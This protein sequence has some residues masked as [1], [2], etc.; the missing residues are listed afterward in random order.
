MV[1]VLVISAEIVDGGF[2]G[3]L[4]SNFLAAKPAIGYPSNNI[5]LFLFQR[6]TSCDIVEFY[7]P[8]PHSRLPLPFTTIATQDPLKV[9]SI[10]FSLNF[11]HPVAVL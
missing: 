11:P 10:E 4:L 3:S 5:Q 9:F 6:N 8:T 1:Q 7:D 2:K